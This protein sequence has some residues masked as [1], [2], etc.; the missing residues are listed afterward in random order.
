M[1]RATDA[2]SH[3]IVAVKLTSDDVGDVSEISDLL[4]QIDADVASLTADGAYNGEA[5]CDSIAD[6]RDAASSSPG[7]WLLGSLWR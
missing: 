5:V 7:I 4:D 2:P 1:S 6:R 3:E